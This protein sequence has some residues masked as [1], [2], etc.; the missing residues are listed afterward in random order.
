MKSRNSNKF[1]YLK[2]SGLQNK[3]Q[4]RENRRHKKVNDAV[5]NF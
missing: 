3:I 1:L 2:T 5:Y 4:F